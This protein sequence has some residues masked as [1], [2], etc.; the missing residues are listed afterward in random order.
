VAHD[1][2]AEKI[3]TNLHCDWLV[4]L[5]TDSEYPR[6]AWNFLE[7]ITGYILFTSTGRSPPLALRTQHFS[8]PAEPSVA[9][10]SPAAFT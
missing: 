9:F 8:E 1:A 6:S 2:L 4:G 5:L 7:L 3:A 10:A